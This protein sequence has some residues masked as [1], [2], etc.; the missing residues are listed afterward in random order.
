[1]TLDKF[2]ITDKRFSDCRLR[3]YDAIMRVR[4]GVF[5]LYEKS[6]LEMKT[7]YGRS[8]LDL[9]FKDD[10]GN[11]E[12]YNP[13]WIYLRAVKWAED[14]DYDYSRPDSFPSEKIVIDPK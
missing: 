4:L 12:E 11:F 8:T 1:M 2:G 13:N 3:A 10:A 7:L 9:E 5:D 6:L 14:L